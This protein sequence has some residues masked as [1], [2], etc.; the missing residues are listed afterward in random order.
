MGDEVWS[1]GRES[2]LRIWNM[3]TMRVKKT[4]AGHTR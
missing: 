3:R 2:V 4:L 1:C